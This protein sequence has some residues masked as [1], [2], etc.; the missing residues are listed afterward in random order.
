MRTFNQ[1]ALIKEMV[2]AAYKH[3]NGHLA[4][5]LSALPIISEIYETFDFDNDV[6]IL[7][8]GHACLALFAVLKACGKNPDFSQIHPD[9]DQANGV[10]C[11]TGSL[12]HGLPVAV[13]AAMAKILVQKNRKTH[14]GEVHVLLGDGECQEGTLWESVELIQ[15]FLLPNITIHIDDNGYQATSKTLTNPR[16]ISSMFASVNFR[17]YGQQKG[18]GLK[19]FSKHPDWHVHELTKDE[20]EICLRELDS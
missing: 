19:M 1:K 18:V 3:K 8:K 20:Y 13:G 4:S 2:E 11:T 16:A 14:K 10:Y 6:F 5:S 7:S 15:R 17:L 12:G 9:I